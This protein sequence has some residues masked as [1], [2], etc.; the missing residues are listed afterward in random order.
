MSKN[1]QITKEDTP[2]VQ[3]IFD[4]L[5]NALEK[6]PHDLGNDPKFG[7]LAVTAV[8]NMACRIAMKIGILKEE[9]IKVNTKIWD[10]KFAPPEDKVWN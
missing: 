7:A 2:S 10:E 5:V 8:I 3:V 4:I 6:V 9:F 1:I